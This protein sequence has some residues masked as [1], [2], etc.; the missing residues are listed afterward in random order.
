M[1]KAYAD[2]YDNQLCIVM[3]NFDYVYNTGWFIFDW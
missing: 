1:R 2:I 3:I